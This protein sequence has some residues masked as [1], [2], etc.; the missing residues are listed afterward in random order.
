MV[1]KKNIYSVILLVS[2]LIIIGFALGNSQK[3]LELGRDIISLSDGWEYFLGDLPKEENGNF[4]FTQSSQVQWNSYRLG[5][6]ISRED[7]TQILWV[8]IK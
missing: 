3:N 7:N 2:L 5:Q 8:K 6:S 4:I 1:L